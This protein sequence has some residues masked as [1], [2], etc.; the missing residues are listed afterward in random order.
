[1]KKIFVHGWGFSKKIWKD[2][3]YFDDALFFDL[4]S[5]GENKHINKSLSE[6]VAD[7]SSMA[8][9]PSI[10]IGWSLGATVSVLSSIR[11]PN[12]KKLILIGFSPKFNDSH[13]GSDPKVVKAFMFNL[14]KDYESTV[15]NFR[16]SAIGTDFN[17][18]FPQK[19]GATKILSEF[20]DIDLTHQLKYIKAKT[21]LIHGIDD[22]IVNPE[23]C[24]FSHQEIKDSEVI[25]LKSHHAPFL[26]WDIFEVIDD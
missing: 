5:H 18:D 8:D 12:I 9:E 24:M 3:F 19:D 13:L 21:F 10:L 2:Y 23:A 1:M 22:I 16:K 14:R 15:L 17:E 6:V 11:N 25:L 4:P 20:I 26:E 7:V